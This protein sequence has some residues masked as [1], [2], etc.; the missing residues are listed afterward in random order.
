M[1][2]APRL[3]LERYAVI[4]LS[5]VVVGIWETFYIFSR[6]PIDRSMI[7]F[8]C[9]GLLVYYFAVH[10]KPVRL[11]DKMLANVASQ[12]LQ[13]VFFFDADAACG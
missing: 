3:Y 10:Y 2:T 12:M 4:F 6:S 9:F 13:G 7:G 8:A 5:M 11:L 1:I